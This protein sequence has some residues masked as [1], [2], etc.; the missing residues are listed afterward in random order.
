[1]LILQLLFALFFGTVSTVHVPPT[2][3][4]DE[5]P[6]PRQVPSDGSAQEAD[7]MM[8][9]L[10]VVE[11][12]DVVL[13]ES[14]PVQIQLQVHG[15]HQDGCEADVEVVQRREGNNVIVELYRVLPAAVMCPMVL[16]PLEETI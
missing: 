13:L 10:G 16:Q 9:V 2:P 4:V 1:T 3:I 7:G 12:V 15:Y 6:A 8:R 14:F 11:S 5:I